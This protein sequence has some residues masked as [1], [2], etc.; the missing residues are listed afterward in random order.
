MKFFAF[1]FISLFLLSTCS[2]TQYNEVQREDCQDLNWQQLGEIESSKGLSQEMLDYHI[3]RCPPEI[4]SAA[5]SLYLKGYQQGIPNYCTYQT[6]FIK[7]DV[8][9]PIPMI[10]EDPN[11]SDFH[12]GYREGIRVSHK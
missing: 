11:F 7:G 2:T 9:D 6:G 3:R 10:C 4:E 5:R 1:L 8:G 12:K